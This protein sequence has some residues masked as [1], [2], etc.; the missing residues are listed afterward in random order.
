MWATI[1]RRTFLVG[2]SAALLIQAGL[3]DSGEDVGVPGLTGNFDPYG[4][5]SFI[6]RRWPDVR[7][8]RPYPDYGVDYSALLPANHAV[9]G[10]TV[11]V[12]LHEAQVID[13]R[14]VTAVKDLL[15]WDE[16]AR[17]TARG[18]L[19]AACRERGRARFFLMDSREARRRAATHGATV[20]IP[21]A[22]ELDDLTFALLWACASLDTGLQ[23]DDQELSATI[24]ELTPYEEL[25]SS[26]VSREAA[27]TLGATAHMWLGSDFCARHILRNMA[28]LRN[29]PVFW[30]REQTGSEACPW[31]LFEHKYAYLRATSDRFDSGGLSRMF[32][33]PRLAIDGSP[34]YQRLLLMLAIALMEATGITV[35]V[36]DDLAYSEVEGFVLGGTDQAIIANWV[37]GEGLWHVDTS[38]RTSVLS[39][40]REA[41]GRASAHSVIDAPTPAGRLR[42]L[43]HYLGIDWPWLRGRC[44]QLASVGTAG[45]LRP[46]SRHMSAAGVDVACAYVGQAGEDY[47]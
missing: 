36:C 31:L 1:G 4:F 41:S 18:L 27:A 39:D 30:A 14:A 37:R 21:E 12:Q 26:A 24:A 10:A 29:I 38:R 7:L 25:P 40:F 34:L 13:S 19:V 44:Q 17:G 23:A 47:A 32:C 6:S 2:T 3:A 42:A 28:S 11:Q 43:A 5:G 8:A 16:F 15:R 9:E 33:L 20:P 35:K 22:Y 45:L 46:R